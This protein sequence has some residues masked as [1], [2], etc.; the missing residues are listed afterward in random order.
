MYTLRVVRTLCV[1]VVALFYAELYIHT[2]NL[3][4]GMLQGGQKPKNGSFQNVKVNDSILTH[5]QHAYEYCV[6]F[7]TVMIC[8]VGL[9]VRT[10]QVAVRFFLYCSGP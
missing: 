1:V 4:I 3:T 6:C 9:C 8:K 10:K 5:Q 7:I 2:C